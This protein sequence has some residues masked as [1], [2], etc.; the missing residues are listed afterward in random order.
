MSDVLFVRQDHKDDKLGE[1]KRVE[2]LTNDATGS[3]LIG[4]WRLKPKVPSVKPETIKIEY[5]AEDKGGA[6]YME[7]LTQVSQKA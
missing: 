1:P 4:V 7:V 6:F 2:Q 3:G 5:K